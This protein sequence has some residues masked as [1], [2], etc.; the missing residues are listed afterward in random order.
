MART[1]SGSARSDRATKPTRSTNRIDTIFRSSSSSRG[2]ESIGRGRLERSPAVVRPRRALG[3]GSAPPSGCSDRR[4]RGGDRSPEHAL[5][6]GAAPRGSSERPD[7]PGGS[8]AVPVGRV[9]R[10]ARE[11]AQRTCPSHVS[12]SRAA[13]RRQRRRDPP[14]ALGLF[15][16][17]SRLAVWSV[18]RPRRPP[19]RPGPR[20]GAGA[21]CRRAVTLRRDRPCAAAAA[22]RPRGPRGHVLQREAGDALVVV[23]QLLQ[24]AWGDVALDGDVPD[25]GPH[26]WFMRRRPR[27]I[28]L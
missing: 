21:E 11:V 7:P 27:L 8:R 22:A 13:P 9:R 4:D 17:R 18:A 14:A 24:L 2:G 25:E 16:W 1:S 23:G 12:S 15:D 6:R 20:P 28:T 10:L 5:R 19:Q 3:P 26:F